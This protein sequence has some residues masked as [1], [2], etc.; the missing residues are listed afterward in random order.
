M[1]LDDTDATNHH[2]SKIAGYYFSSTLHQSIVP[3][4][5]EIS[6]P[7]AK[8]GN[9]WLS[10]QQAIYYRRVQQHHHVSLAI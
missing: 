6:R 5:N 9:G 7:L 4:I 8:Q 1:G 10:Q 3:I 2:F